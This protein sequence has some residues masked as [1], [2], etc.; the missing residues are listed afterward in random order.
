MRTKFHPSLF[1]GNFES[2]VK[3]LYMRVKVFDLGHLKVNSLYH[4]TVAYK[5]SKRFFFAIV[6]AIGLFASL[7][8]LTLDLDGKTINELPVTFLVFTFALGIPLFTATHLFIERNRP[9][10]YQSILFFLIEIGYL[11]LFWRHS[12]AYSDTF[13]PPMVLFY[14]Y[15]AQFLAVHGLLAISVFNRYAEVND[16]WNFNA[17]LLIRM[18]TGIFYTGVLILGLCGALAALKYLFNW[19][20]QLRH[21]LQII[22]FLSSIYMT[23]YVLA[24]IRIDLNEYKRDYYYPV[25]LR[26]FTQFVLLPLIALYLLILYAYELKII[27]HWS[28]PVGWVS[29]LIL[30]FSIIGILAFLLVYPLRND[31]N[32]TWIKKFSRLFYFAIIPLIILLFL[33]IFIRIQSYGITIDRYIVWVLSLWLAGITTYFLISRRDNII[34]IP[35]S[36]SI[37]FLLST[38]GPWGFDNIAAH[39][40]VDRLKSMLTITNTTVQEDSPNAANDILSYLM[41][42]HDLKILHALKNEQINRLLINVNSNMSRYEVQG[43]IVNILNLKDKYK[44]AARSYFDFKADK[45]VSQNL[46]GNYLIL[47]LRSSVNETI[48]LSGFSLQLRDTTLIFTTEESKNVIKLIDQAMIDQWIAMEGKQQKLLPFKIDTTI[49]YHG[50]NR[51]LLINIY[52]LH[53]AKFNKSLQ[54]SYIDAVLLL[55]QD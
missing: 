37:V 23:L 27:V 55:Q 31:E 53:S 19:D 42:Y 16:F 47:P 34:Y 6:S 1:R 15:G 14:K 21:Y 40:Q 38:F 50:K 48:T 25:G 11:Y 2:F 4:L 33:A 43:E 45:L 24:G 10:L 18:L 41:D 44:E 12:L 30:W 22:A 39:S 5:V 36:L 8:Y 32:Q 51:Q 26:I 20:I 17:R 52:Q 54:V 7:Y 13:D 29:N 28:L 46:I 9:L 35:L 49:P 3:N